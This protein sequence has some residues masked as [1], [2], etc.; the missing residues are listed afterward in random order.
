MAINR[1]CL[2]QPG[3]STRMLEAK[4]DE[5]LLSLLRGSCLD[6][7]NAVLTEETLRAFTNLWQSGSCQYALTQQY[8]QSLIAAIKKHYK[9]S[10]VAEAAV[11]AVDTLCHNNP[12]NAESVLIAG[13]GIVMI[14]IMRTF[15]TD[16]KKI[17][18]CLKVLWNVIAAAM[19]SM[20]AK[21]NDDDE[22]EQGNVKLVNSIGLFN[23]AV[24]DAMRA[25]PTSPD[26]AE[27]GCDMVTI[28]ADDN[29]PNATLLAR[30]GVGDVLSGVLRTHRDDAAV[31]ERCVQSLV[32]LSQLDD[33]E[34]KT[35][36]GN[37]GV[38]EEVVATA[39]AH[40]N[41]SKLLADGINAMYHLCFDHPANRAKVLEAQGAEGL[42]IVLRTYRGNN[43]DNVVA[44]AIEGVAHLFAEDDQAA[45]GRLGAMGFCEAIVSAMQACPDDSVQENGADTMTKLCEGHAE[46]QQRG[47]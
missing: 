18:D 10:E 13:G 47:W 26:I 11:S 46:N 16:E 39:K 21:G 9:E 43:A 14:A 7:E 38:C 34:V 33:E 29:L 20:D 40:L 23:K 28:L 12:D 22:H 41:D 30:A 24:V 45:K 2:G 15:I 42:L 31:V 8:S 3:N 27:I 32:Y 1:L 37:A 44:E 5:I 19:E 17:S 35:A 6:Q 4:V 25:H 36:L